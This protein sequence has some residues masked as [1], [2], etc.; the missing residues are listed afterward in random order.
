MF[1]WKYC[2]GLRVPTSGDGRL[3]YKRCVYG[4]FIYLKT[5]R[6]LRT[7]RIATIF[8][9]VSVAPYESVIG[10][11]FESCVFF[12][13]M[14]LNKVNDLLTKIVMVYTG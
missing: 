10:T 4:N 14:I 2:S 5:G 8:V 6:R 3:S 1:V 13:R 9:C 11:E 7:Q 12:Y